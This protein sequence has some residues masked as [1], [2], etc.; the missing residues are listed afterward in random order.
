MTCNSIDDNKRG[1][2]SWG[3]GHRLFNGPA[4]PERRPA[5]HYAAAC[6]EACSTLL[7]GLEKTELYVSHLCWA[8]LW[9]KYGR[10]ADPSGMR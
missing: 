7:W 9:S 6:G 2:A 10:D 3:V 1:I 4:S 8:G 5:I